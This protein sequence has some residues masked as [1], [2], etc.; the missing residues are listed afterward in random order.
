M[1]YELSFTKR[2]DVADREQYFNECCVGGDVVINQLL[3]V[4]RKEYGELQ[5]NQED[6]GWF[7]WFSEA[8]TDLAVDV[9]CD[10]PDTGEFRIHLTSRV[11]RVLFGCKVAD[12]P[13]LEQLRE[14]VLAVLVPW[15]GQQPQVTRLD[16]KYM[17]AEKAT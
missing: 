12:T 8:G 9:F 2:V 15:V 1:P 4:L 3:P 17:P 10:N 13:P 6:W 5:T 7:A 14:R 16:A 11:R